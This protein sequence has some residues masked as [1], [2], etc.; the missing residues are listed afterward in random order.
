M[1]VICYNNIAEA[2]MPRLGVL[3]MENYFSLQ[4]MLEV[5]WGRLINL[6]EDEEVFISPSQICTDTRDVKKGDL[7]LALKGENFDGHDFVVEAHKK[8]ARGAIVT[9]P[10]LPLSNNFFL[11]QVRDTLKALQELAKFYRHRLLI[12]LIAITGSNGKTTVKELV[13]RI[14]STRHLTFKSQG[15]FNNQIGVPLSILGINAGH[16]AAVLELGMNQPG[17][18]G[19]LSRVA[20]P[21]IGVITNVHSSHLGPLGTVANIARAKAEMIPFLN[22]SRENHLV[23]NEDDPWSRFFRKKAI[24]KVVTFAVNSQADFKACNVKDE[25]AQVKFDLLSFGSES[26]SIRL[27]FPGVFNVYNVLAAS[28]VCSILG[29]SLPE[30]KKAVETFSPPPLHYQIEQCGEYNILNDCYNANPESMKSA[31]YTLKNLKGGRKV[32]ILGDMLELGERSAFLHESLGEFAASLNIDA[33]FTCGRFATY[34]VEG[35][36]KRGLKDSFCFEHKKSLLEELLNY[37][38]CGDWLLFK[39]SRNTHMEKL[40]T[41]LKDSV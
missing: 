8:G 34:V 29:F 26:V 41:M 2:K 25:G 21:N 39:G 18:I 7:F 19:I 6:C 38:N 28:T 11:V 5:I 10:S 15:N 24:C 31:L 35:A 16:G 20:Q 27:P 14:I 36:K 40:I 17:E 12:P 32:A 30:I 1:R 9:D 13:A 33:L 23:L 37:I 3:V 4:E 22:R